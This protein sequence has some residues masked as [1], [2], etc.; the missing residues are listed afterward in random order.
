MDGMFDVFVVNC[1][2][3]TFTCAGTPGEECKVTESDYCGE[4][5]DGSYSKTPDMCYGRFAR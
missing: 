2:P 4:S 3:Y 5:T 1:Y